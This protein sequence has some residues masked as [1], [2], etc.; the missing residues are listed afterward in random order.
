VWRVKA[1]DLPAGVP[2]VVD[3]NGN[4]FYVDPMFT[5]PAF[6]REGLRL[7]IDEA[8]RVASDLRLPECLPITESNLTRS[9]ISSFGYTYIR[10]KLGNITTSNYVYGV[11]QGFK[12]SDLSVVN[13]D[14][15]CHEY[16]EKYQW[17]IARFDTNTPCQLATQW[18]VAARVD[19]AG[20]HRECELHVA[21][22]PY[23]NDVELGKLPKE[24]F[25][26][27]YTVWWKPKSSSSQTGGAMVEMFLP[28]K[29]L[30]QFVVDDPKYI[31]RQ[32]LIFTNMNALFPG[33]AEIM[34]NKPGLIR[35]IGA[36]K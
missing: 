23:W 22:N 33:K 12:F 4:I 30:L 5:T 8:N 19:V 31:L 10:K 15:R 9:F 21:V 35:Y 26:P 14:E 3:T 16:R 24:T 1:D 11:E 32:P 2:H 7:I 13:F 29:T 18:L 28:T 25:T 17:P 6:Q 20:L 36:P 27:I 34:T